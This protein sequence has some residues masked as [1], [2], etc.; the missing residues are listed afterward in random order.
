[1]MGIRRL[2]I[3][4]SLA[5]LFGM[6]PCLGAGPLPGSLIEPG[7]RVGQVRIGESREAVHRALGKPAVEDAAMG[8]K[9]TEIWRSGLGLGSK[10]NGRE[11]ELEIFFQGPGA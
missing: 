6:S 8:G 9:L 10:A 3:I 2:G 4:A 7:L 11:E 5:W 1:M